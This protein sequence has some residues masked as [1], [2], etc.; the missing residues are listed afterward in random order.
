M[1]MFYLVLTLSMSQIVMP[2]KY[3]KEQC[4]AAGKSFDDRLSGHW[5][6]CIPAPKGNCRYFETPVSGMVQGSGYSKIIKECD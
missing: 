5:H 2:E 3:I 1:E 4:E 6:Y